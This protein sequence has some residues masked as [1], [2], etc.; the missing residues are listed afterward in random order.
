M[1]GLGYAWFASDVRTFTHPAEV[2]TGLPILVVAVLLVRGGRTRREPSDAPASL[3]G[4]VALAAVLFIWEMAMLFSSPRH[5]YPTMSSIGNA[6]LNTSRITHTAV[7][8]MWLA[9]GAYLTRRAWMRP[10]S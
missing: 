8:A 7:F 4:W 6:V 3:A 5:D 1:V 2:L 10:A 9:L